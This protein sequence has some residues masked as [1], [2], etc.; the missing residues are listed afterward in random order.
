MWEM[1]GK[2]A[3]AIDELRRRKAKIIFESVNQHKL[4]SKKNGD[5]FQ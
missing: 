2:N 1:Y 5:E 3:C 4:E